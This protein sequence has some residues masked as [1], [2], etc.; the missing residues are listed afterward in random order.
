M[1]N[2]NVTVS[3]HLKLHTQ[4]PE[5]WAKL[6]IYN[7]YHYILIIADKKSAR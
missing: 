3:K 5:N 4:K 6:L 7:F 2:S 1:Q